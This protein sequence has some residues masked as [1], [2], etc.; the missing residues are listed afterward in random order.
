MSADNVCH[1][2]QP[3]CKKF[4][5]AIINR[6]VLEAAASIPAPTAEDKAARK[7]A[8]AERKA[9]RDG[10]DVDIKAVTAELEALRAKPKLTVKEQADVTA[11]EA[12][13]KEL[14]DAKK[15]AMKP[16]PTPL[17]AI[18]K[19]RIDYN[20]KFRDAITFACGTVLDEVLRDAVE[21]TTPS[22]PKGDK[23]PTRKV[24]LD[25]VR[26][27]LARHPLSCIAGTV[28]VREYPK[29]TKKKPAAAPAS[30]DVP[31]DA[32]PA[33]DV[34]ATPSETTVKENN[35]LSYVAFLMKRVKDEREFSLS[36]S[37]DA[38]HFLSDTMFAL[39]RRLAEQMVVLLAFSKQKR[40]TKETVY[41]SLR[42][43]VL[44][45]GQSSEVVE[46]LVASTDAFVESIH[47]PKTKA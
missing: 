30:T 22:E 13:L 44:A 20:A 41:A 18:N 25:L 33:A 15:A 29:P 43:L 4:V 26:E 23:K 46:A 37:N 32:T 47:P 39:L 35:F 2:Q 38:K 21:H 14:K 7:A 45:S 17:T 36:I 24:T 5:N 8:N 34:A 3:A 19:D 1:H 16:T 9:V 27:S 31:A 12:R 42:S 11:K 6:K 28:A 10:L 40:V